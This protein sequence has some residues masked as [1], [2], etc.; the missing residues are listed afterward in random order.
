MSPLL[1]PPIKA[2]AIYLTT[3]FVC[4]CLGRHRDTFG[5]YLLTERAIFIASNAE[6]QKGVL[7]LIPVLAAADDNNNKGMLRRRSTRR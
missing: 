4:D 5:R 7:M 1:L 6:Q 3:L 2:D